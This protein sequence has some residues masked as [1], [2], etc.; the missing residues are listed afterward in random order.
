MPEQ[1]DHSLG[2][3]GS[4]CFYKRANICWRVERGAFQRNDESPAL[5]CSER[6]PH[7]P[8]RTWQEGWKGE[9]KSFQTSIHLPL[10]FPH[11][12]FSGSVSLCM[13]PPAL[14]T[15]LVLIWVLTKAF[16]G[17]AFKETYV[18]C[19]GIRHN[20]FRRSSSRKSSISGTVF[21]CLSKKFTTEATSKTKIL[22]LRIQL[23]FTAISNY[24]FILPI[25]LPIIGL[26]GS[27]INWM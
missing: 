3:N 26:I 1:V 13:S 25:I 24:F 16:F 23:V 9:R 7:V 10:P 21:C 14:W 17:R 22:L 27:C 15:F 5:D 20:R 4:H 6:S 2:P 12:L 11:A 8:T 19:C 18:C